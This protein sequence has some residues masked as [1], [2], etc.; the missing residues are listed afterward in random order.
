MIKRSKRT[1]ARG[2]A[3]WKPKPETLELVAS[4]RAVL[5]EYREHLPLTVRQVFYRLVGTQGYDKTEAAY[6]RLC[7]TV[8]RARRARL[9]D[10]ASIRDDG[11]SRY[12]R[13]AW[14]DADAFI[15]D[16][17]TEAERFR[18]DRQD[19]QAVRLWLLCEAQGMAPMLYRAASAYSVPVLSSGGFDSLTAKHDL[20]RELAGA[21]RRGQR[22]EVLHV[23]DHDPSGTHLFSSLAEDVSAM[24]VELVGKLPTFTRLAVTVEQI[25]AFN[26][27]TAPPKATDRRAFEGDTVQAE[28]LPPDVLS[29]IV[30]EAIEA[31]R[32]RATLE[33][34]LAA[35]AGHRTALT[36]MLG[37]RDG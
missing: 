15:S 37:G 31:R 30:R 13:T 2:F 10:F 25:E 36:E 33:Q 8:N 9:I 11:A 19:G 34:V 1:R 29:G 24:C 14:R 12:E 32:D 17:R 28:A 16:M 7:E 27:P 5:D 6:G 3:P 20:A 18:L 35:E 26:L 21:L 4:V 22:A 23:G